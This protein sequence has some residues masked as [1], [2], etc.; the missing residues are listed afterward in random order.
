MLQVVDIFDGSLHSCP[1][2]TAGCPV[3]G[4]L[5]SWSFYVLGIF[6]ACVFL[7]GPKTSFGQSEQNPAFW[8]QLLLFM[9]A[10]GSK[11]SWHDPTVELTKSRYLSAGDW[12][13]WVRFLMSFF[14]NGVGFHIL[15][16]ALPIQVAGQSSLTGVVFRAVGMLYLV[17]LD[18]TPGYTLTFTD[19]NDEEIK[20]A[21]LAKDG[22]NDRNEGT[23]YSSDELVMTSVEQIIQEARNKLD[24][25]AAGAGSGDG[26]H[27]VNLSSGLVL[28]AHGG[29]GGAAATLDKQKSIEEKPNSN[30]Q[31]DEMAV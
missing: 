23:D 13:V 2:G 30:S 28:A 12:R 5:G 4:T 22:N 25:L 26:G 21:G 16:H 8:M 20:A 11:V 9:K 29:Y 14:I 24:V 6:M 10:T 27:V 7:L 19:A 17:D 18:D 15:V 3:V 1:D 31:T